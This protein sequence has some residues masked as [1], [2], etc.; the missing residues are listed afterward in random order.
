ML[1]FLVSETGTDK[2]FVRGHEEVGFEQPLKTLIRRLIDM[3]NGKS[4]Y[5]AAVSLVNLSKVVLDT[6]YYLNWFFSNHE[7]WAEDPDFEM[8]MR[9][10]ASNTLVFDIC[11]KFYIH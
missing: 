6:T 11:H 2:P 7:Y 1:N 3:E 5:M 9:S 4:V 8:R 10:Q